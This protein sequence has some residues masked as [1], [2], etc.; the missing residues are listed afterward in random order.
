M[1]QAGEPGDAAHLRAQDVAFRV[2]QDLAAFLRHRSREQVIGAS[3]ALLVTGIIVFEFVIDAKIVTEGTNHGDSMPSA[4]ANNWL[5]MSVYPPAR[6]DQGDHTCT[7]STTAFGSPRP[8]DSR[9]P[10]DLWTARPDRRTAGA[11]SKQRRP[12]NPQA[13]HQQKSLT[14]CIF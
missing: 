7:R 5:V 4:A 10:V 3:L 14:N 6:T 2:E 9:R 11:A 1:K 8:S 12:Q 13:Q